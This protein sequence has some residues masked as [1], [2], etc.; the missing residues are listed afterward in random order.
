MTVF[1]TILFAL[2]Y[3]GMAIGRV[4][5]SR[6]DRTGIAMIA[7]VVLVVAGA[8]PGAEVAGAIHFP[9]L[10][11]LAG[12]MI[13]SARVGAAG[14]Y[15][16]AAAWIARQ[17]GQPLRLL[18]LTIAI[19]GVLSALLV[20]DIVVFAMTPLLCAGLAARQLDARPFLFGL[21][22]ASN[23]GSA[24]TLIGNPQNIMIGQ[25]GDLGFWSYSAAAIVPSIL[26]LVISFACIAWVWR[27]SLRAEA[28]PA[29]IAA[30]QFDRQQTGMCGIALVV[31]LVLFTTS[32][33]REVSA[34]LIAACLIVSRKYA[35]RQLLD[36]VDLPLLILF[37]ALFV[38]NDAFARTG[39]AEQAMGALE[40]SGL[41][42]DRVTLLA[43]LAL[44][45]SNTIGNVP[46][47]VMILKVWQA[48]PEG[49]LVGL[50]ILSTFAGNLLLVG[51]LANLIVA[52]RAAGQ[53]VHLSF[54]DH[55]KAGVPITL[56]SM[57]VA[58]LWLWGTG[59]M[60]W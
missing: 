18:A 43:P 24:A 30:S 1:I 37:A 41:L 58:G 51:S 33:P 29:P 20:N 22:A 47:V 40:A 60:N 53:G 38:V 11:L 32:L 36:E 15:D 6:V 46:A 35:T 50:A 42:P 48:I 55:A 3:V 44:A 23:A 4:P 45:V 27:G 39:L 26:G 17:A 9:T 31:L 12:L 54:Q 56:I 13:L 28:T 10:L 8:L 25:V 14:F 52:E 5:G 59:L 19:G 21:A 2:T 16:A 34:L 57:L 49:T 7:A